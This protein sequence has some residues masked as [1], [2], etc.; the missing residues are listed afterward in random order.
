MRAFVT[1][2]LYSQLSA[3]SGRSLTCFNYKLHRPSDDLD[4]AE[5]TTDTVAVF[6]AP[7]L[8]HAIEFP[9]FYPLQTISVANVYY[10]SFISSPQ[11]MSALG[12]KQTIYLIRP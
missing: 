8:N 6:R 11:L 3:T 10:S 7:R 5:I 9:I 2:A 4:R 1:L 12:H